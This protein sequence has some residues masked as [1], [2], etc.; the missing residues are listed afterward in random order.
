MKIPATKRFFLA[1]H[2]SYIACCRF[3]KRSSV[4]S[5]LCHIFC[6]FYNKYIPP[7]GFDR[8]GLNTQ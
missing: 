8:Q 2:Y 1:A 5:D 4:K 7:I 6:P 3:L